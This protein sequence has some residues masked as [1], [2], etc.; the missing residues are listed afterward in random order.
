MMKHGLALALLAAPF[1]VPLAAQAQTAT[2][3]GPV[4]VEIVSTGQV[5]VPAQRFRLSVTLTAKGKDEAAAGATLA[6]NKAK[7]IRALAA[8]N[9][10]EAK[11]DIGTTNSLVGLISTF[12]G[13]KSKPSFSVE[14]LDE[15][16]EETP[17]STATET[18]GFD[19]P[20]RA[21]V[22]RAKAPVE[23]S[24]GTLDE[25]VLPL[26]NDYV[27]PTRAAKAAAIK[28]AQDEA[29]AYAATL[30]LKRST[31][32]KVSE[33]QDPTAGALA[34][35]GELV[36]IVAPKKDGGVDQVTVNASLVVEFQLSR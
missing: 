13:T 3:A 24:G 30:G 28:K 23:V 33:K 21:A 18:V 2:A 35:I 8:L 27:A 22:E 20:T 12:A 6:A 17:Q 26:L 16:S 11:G 10:G 19:A 14:T 32:V 34:L 29:D 9:I 31:I 5:S 36:T 1:S 25:D 4:S 15:D 7:L